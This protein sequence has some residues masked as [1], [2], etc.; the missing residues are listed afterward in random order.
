MLILSPQNVRKAGKVLFSALCTFTMTGIN[1]APHR[2]HTA[3]SSNV[4]SS[5]IAPVATTYHVVDKINLHP[6]LSRYNKRQADFKIMSKQPNT[7]PGSLPSDPFAMYKYN[8]VVDL[9]ELRADKIRRTIV[10]GDIHGSLVGFEGFLKQIKYDAKADLIILAGD[11]V[12]K[13][14]QSHEVIDKARSINAKCV[15]GNHDDKVIRWKGY[16]DSLDPKQRKKLENDLD[17][18]VPAD[19]AGDSEHYRIAK[20]L[21]QKQ[22][23]YMLSCPLI[24]TLP[25]EISVHKVPV[26]VVHAG[27]DPTVSLKK[28]KPWVLFNIRNILKDGTPSRKKKKGVSWAQEFNDRHSKRVKNGIKDFMVLYGHDAGRK[29]NVKKW[30]IGLDTRC[31]YG[32][33]LTGYNVQTGDFYKSPCPNLVNDSDDD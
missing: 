31:V 9:K 19:L 11:I 23:E 21:T 10:V 17:G 22:Y 14:P 18:S 5:N 28:Q 1:G 15:R 2:A 32:K 29:L 30:S 26:H 13:G 3:S 20:A 33:E 7:P 27:I 25:K 24:L 16:L 4:S 6:D 12:A 8:E